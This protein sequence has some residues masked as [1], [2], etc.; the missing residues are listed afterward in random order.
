MAGLCELTHVLTYVR[1]YVLGGGGLSSM[2]TQTS[3]G[4]WESSWE[5]LSLLVTQR[6]SQPLIWPSAIFSEI[7]KRREE[8]GR[9]EG[10]KTGEDGTLGKISQAGMAGA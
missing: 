9:G 1:Q 7:S 3:S 6:G 10:R 2:Y 8:R 5:Y 4:H